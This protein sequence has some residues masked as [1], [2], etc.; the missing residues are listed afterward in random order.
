MLVGQHGKDI[1]LT[2]LDA[3][4]MVVM[5][6]DFRVTVPDRLVQELHL[7]PS[8]LWVADS[9]G[10]RLMLTPLQDLVESSEAPQDISIEMVDCYVCGSKNAKTVRFC[11]TCGAKFS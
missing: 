7:Q 2:K 10:R 1:D 11:G 9:D 5:D 4:R 8:S 3:T 6:S